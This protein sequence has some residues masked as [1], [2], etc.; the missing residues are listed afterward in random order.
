MKSVDTA[1]NLH[2]MLDCVVVGGEA[3]LIYFVFVEHEA[4]YDVIST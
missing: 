2:D 4:Q 3:A 1:F